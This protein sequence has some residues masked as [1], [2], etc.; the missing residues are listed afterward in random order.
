MK[1]RTRNQAGFTLVEIAIVLVIIGL[2]LGGVLKGQELIDN[3][4][5]K[6]AIKD[7]DGVAAAYYSYIDRFRQIPGDDGP[8]GTVQARG[9]AWTTVTAGNANG[10]LAVASNQ[11]FTVNG[12]SLPFWQH[13]KAAGFINGDPSETTTA[14][15][16]RNAFGGLIGVT[17]IGITGSPPG[18]KV[19]MSLVPGK[20][21]R[22]IDAQLDD[23]LP[24]LG[25]IR[26]TG[27][28]GAGTYTPGAPTGTVYTDDNQ[29]TIC[30]Q[31]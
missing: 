19:C 20:I 12:E 14:I 23:G 26:A 9:S 30:R 31:M 11:A 8:V 16:P 4:K 1:K 10:V 17:N 29:Y 2:L 15:L 7:L 18:N 13:L 27:G 22:A 28:T 6:N 21:A 25:T 3:S 24:Q 5:A